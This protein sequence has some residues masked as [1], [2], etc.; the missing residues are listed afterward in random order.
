[1]P[2]CHF[3]ALAHRPVVIWS[4]I[5]FLSYDARRV[6]LQR[7]VII[8]YEIHV[9]RKGSGFQVTVPTRPREITVDNVV[10]IGESVRE[11][12]EHV[13][14]ILNADFGYAQEGPLR[15]VAYVLSTPLSLSFHVP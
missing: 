3:S 14:R 5:T 10:A 2:K 9:Q 13:V 12:V 6:P 7:I 15:D 4:L 11:E 1:M 8:A